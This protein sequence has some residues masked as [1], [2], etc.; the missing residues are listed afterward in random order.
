MPKCQKGYKWSRKTQSCIVR[1]KIKDSG[2]CSVGGGDK[3]SAYGDGSKSGPKGAK[4]KAQKGPFKK[5][6]GGGGKRLRLQQFCNTHPDHP[7]CKDN[8]K[9]IIEEKYKFTKR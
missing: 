7:D 6:P 1:K 4:G 8:K 5:S 3:C 9:I 2:S